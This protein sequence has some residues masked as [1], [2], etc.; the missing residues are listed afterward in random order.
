MRLNKISLFFITIILFSLACM[1]GNLPSS[2]PVIAPTETRSVTAR[3]TR[4]APPTPLPIYPKAEP[5]PLWV[6]DFADPI[7]TTIADRRPNFQDDFSRY[8]GWVNVMSEV[9]G[10]VYAERF[11]EMLLLKLPEKTKNS[12]F[13]NPWVNRANFV[14]T[15][16][17]RF[18][19][20]QPHDTVRFQFDQFPDQS[21]AFDL[22][23]NKNWRLEWGAQADRQ[24]VTGIYEHFPPEH[25]SVTIIMQGTQC[26]IYLNN[27]PLAYSSDCRA[28]SPF[29]SRGWVASFRLLRDTERAVVVNFDN[30]KLWDLDKIPN[31]P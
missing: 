18:Y 7:L 14:L 21:V 5:I 27:D 11:D 23:N 9:I 28:A 6:T 25:I 8:R 22:S 31:L 16:D 29:P 3:P 15:L 17:L 19:Q 26:A 2:T 1:A 12:I 4:T 13:Y 24:S 30:L 10:P 20:S